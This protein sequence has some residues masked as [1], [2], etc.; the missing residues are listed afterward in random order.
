MQDG[1][2][3]CR[4]Q[5]GGQ[6]R[7][8]QN[9]EDNAGQCRTIHNMVDNADQYRTEQN[10]EASGGLC[11]TMQSRVDNAGKYRKMQNI[12]DNAGQCQ[13]VQ[14][15]QDNAESSVQQQCRAV[16]CQVYKIFKFIC[17]HPIIMLFIRTFLVFKLPTI[18]CEASAD[19]DKFS[20]GHRC[21]LSSYLGPSPLSRQ[22]WQ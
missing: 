2:E 17:R 18:I 22:L 4:L 20:E 16:P 3:Q 19:L 14:N 11:R 10:I 6:C 7:T 13:T 8:V 5:Y 21:L 12:E 1:A 15:I 9:M